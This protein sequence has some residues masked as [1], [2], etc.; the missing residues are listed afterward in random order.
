MRAFT[1]SV[2][3]L[4]LSL[5]S[6]GC[7]N[8]Q[9]R[10]S[11][12]RQAKTLTETQY[13]QIL[14]NLAMCA[15]DPDSLPSMVSLKSGSTQIGDTGTLGFLGV[16]GL[17]TT[18]GSS[19]TISGSRSIVDQWGTSPVTDDNVLK[20][21]Q[22]AY[23]NTHGISSFLTE[24]DA[25]D[26]GHDLSQ[27][28]G[29]NADISTDA[30]TLKLLA[31]IRGGSLFS[32]ISGAYF[33]GGLSRDLSDI[34]EQLVNTLDEDFLQFAFKYVQNNKVYIGIFP[35]NVPVGNMNP[36]KFM[37][38]S[39]VNERNQPGL[40]ASGLAK[41]TARRINDIQEELGNIARLGVDWYH[42]GSK[43]EIPPDACYVGHYK[44]CGRDC[45]AWV[46]PEGRKQ[47]ADFTRSILKLSGTFKDAQIVTV[48]SGI[49]YSPAFSGPAR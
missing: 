39:A 29:T 4:L 20:L 32:N 16:A 49:Q 13:E 9:L 18:F 31:T 47:L 35:D 26:M 19:P 37:T 15:L 25:N 44:S 45:Y 3:V 12:I 40:P 23:Q 17:M 21:L 36:N 22:M 8:A 14:N 6:T 33:K 48:P 42:C 46:Q 38:V 34:Q 1:C 10:V 7:T 43:H 5:L 27:L 11:T 24:K 41:E 30:D 28:I 2:T